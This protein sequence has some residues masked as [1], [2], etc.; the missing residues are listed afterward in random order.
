MLD[1]GHAVGQVIVSV[2]L[3]DGDRQANGLGELS[4]RWSGSDGQSD[5]LVQMADKWA[6]SLMDRVKWRTD[7]LTL[8]DGMTY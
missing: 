4:Y 8:T 5:G 7:G 1:D 3:P 2:R 6:D